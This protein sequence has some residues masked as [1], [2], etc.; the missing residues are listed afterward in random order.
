MA[1]KKIAPNFDDDYLLDKP[2]WRIVGSLALWASFV[3]A[4]M[5]M[6]AKALAF[7]VLELFT[8]PAGLSVLP[9]LGQVVYA[10]VAILSLLFVVA[11]ALSIFAIARVLVLLLFGGKV[12][13]YKDNGAV[14]VATTKPDFAT[15]PDDPAGFCGWTG[16]LLGWR[17]WAATVVDFT[18]QTAVEKWWS[19]VQI[20]IV[21]LSSEGVRFVIR[22]VVKNDRRLV[23]QFVV[24][25]DELVALRISRGQARS[26]VPRLLAAESRLGALK[27]RLAILVMQAHSRDFGRSPYGQLLKTVGHLALREACSCDEEMATLLG[28]A[29]ANKPPAPDRPAKKPA[30]ADVTQ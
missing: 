18:A 15:I 29:E 4:F 6:G 20:A 1:S 12:W 3:A 9:P 30:P 7:L 17:K 8:P 26:I 19:D 23:N 24:S 27:D 16:G 10:G 11:S 22:E 5:V 21:P 13:V 25:Y 14:C 28:W 2:E